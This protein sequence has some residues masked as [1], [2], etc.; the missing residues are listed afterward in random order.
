M[1]R[2]L[3][4]LSGI[5]KIHYY[6]SVKE[7]YSVPG[8][9]CQTFTE[10]FEKFTGMY[11]YSFPQA[12]YVSI[13]YRDPVASGSIPGIRPFLHLLMLQRNKAQGR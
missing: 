8:N 9:M 4:F 6:T 5:G 11:K 3:K 13:N 7:K 10:N 1:E 12:L 2:F